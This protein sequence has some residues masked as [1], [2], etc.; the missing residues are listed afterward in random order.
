[1]TSPLRLADWEHSHP[2]LSGKFLTI[3]RVAALH[4]RAKL[5]LSPIPLGG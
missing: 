2:T 4:G 1:M 5:P 3:L